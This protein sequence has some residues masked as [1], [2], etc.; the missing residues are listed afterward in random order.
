MFS[1]LKYSPS[2]ALLM[3]TA[4]ISIVMA[5][6]AAAQ[7]I[8]E[9]LDE[10][11]YLRGLSEH[12]LPEILE[13]YIEQNPPADDVA[14]VVYQLVADRM[15]LADPALTPAAREAAL[16]AVLST[17]QRLI[18]QHPFDPRH[19]IWL[20]DQAS[21]LYFVLYPAEATGLTAEFGVPS[22]IQLARAKQV[23]AQMNELAAEAELEIAETILNL[24]SEPDFAAS[25]AK[26]MQRRR[27]SRDE[28]DR[29]IPFLR[30][31]G[32]Y[33]DAKFNITDREEQMASFA[34]AAEVLQPVAE[35]LE[36][37]LKKRAELY[38][39]LALAQLGEYD[40]AEEYFRSVATSDLSSEADIFSARMGGVANR[41]IQRGTQAGLEALESI[42]GRYTTADE[43][44]FRMLIADKRFL[45]RKQLADAASKN[46]RDDLLA[47]AFASYTDL[48]SANLG[49]PR[50]TVRSIVFQKLANAAEGD[51]PLGQ[52]PPIVSVAR[53]VNLAR[54]E[55]TR[56]EAIDIFQAA[57]RRS[58]LDDQAKAQALF[59]L[60]R[61]EY[62]NENWL[63]AALH[64]DQL[65]REHPLDPQADRAVQIA[66][67][68]LVDLHDKNSDSSELTEQL[69]KSLAL[70]LEKYPNL[71]T[72][73]RWRYEMG[74]LRFNSEQFAEA[75]ELFD[76]IPP[77]ADVWLD[78]RFMLAQS[79]RMTAQ[80]ATD[81]SARRTA[82]QRLIDVID[83]AQ[84][85]IERGKSES[86]DQLREA[87]LDFYLSYLRIF[88]SEAL[89][90]LG[91]PMDAIAAIESLQVDPS[92]DHGLLGEVL[93]LRVRAYQAAGQ[94]QK[95]EQEVNAFLHS[96]PDQIGEVVPGML[97]TL[98]AEI[99]SL[100][101]QERTDEARDKAEANLLPLA[102]ALDSWLTTNDSLTVDERLAL[103]LR[104]ADAYRLSGRFQQALEL[105]NS[106]RAR[107][108]NILQANFGRAEALFA[109]QQNE[110]AMIE[111][112][113]ISAS[114]QGEQDRHYWT[115]ELRMLQ[116]L[117]RVNR[118]T[119]K[120][121]PR[122]T[123]L[124][125]QDAE[126]GGSD[127]LNEFIALQNKY[128]R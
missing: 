120:I 94:P 102:D 87:V 18:D 54:D 117:D 55:T 41:T 62:D 80:I 57:L 37:P 27:L 61:A 75:A 23:A 6:P 97:A 26:Q 88:Q 113:R 70:L 111:F 128:A 90:G 109:L 30:G 122:I 44:F 4:T 47:D 15:R 40:A 81:P 52:L 36:G 126:M 21:D 67:A 42:E 89:L 11:K 86:D 68:L 65:A 8:E 83:R 34:L 33:L 125:Q 95:A 103:Q 78:S 82:L 53:A 29:R 66:V 43:V 73:E 1:I 12:G 9:R 79:A 49:V 31:I 46:E 38:A 32:A 76:R 51:V 60:A 107:K 17:R 19:A 77:S 7:S 106:V 50:D 105:Y 99:E 127:L 96:I 22:D 104:L 118:N 123:M 114:Q 39:G 25:M 119:Q 91:R 74:R 93:A 48:L 58:E 10:S 13:H 98:T 71:P 100:L 16:K 112:K 121:E 124:K 35:E 110:E 85:Q 14:R 64:F 59:G 116:I 28:R 2:R 45:L 5:L 108:P 24:E 72:V 92:L 101:Q 115:A 3:L 20:A 56:D 69:E 84:P 63:S